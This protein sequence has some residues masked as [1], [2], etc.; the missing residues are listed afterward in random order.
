[1]NETTYSVV[2][3]PLPRPRRDFPFFRFEASVTLQHDSV[4]L[5]EPLEKPRRVH[6]KTNIWHCNKGI[7]IGSFSQQTK[8][9]RY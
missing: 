1:M 2:Q 5:Q 6:R 8:K 3:R 7:S 9:R 4:A